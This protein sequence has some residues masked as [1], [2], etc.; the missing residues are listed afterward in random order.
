MKKQLYNV[1]V[2][3]EVIVYAV[4]E[5]SAEDIAHSAVVNGECGDADT[6]M[7]GPLQWPP[8]KELLNSIPFGDQG[9]SPDEPAYGPTGE[10][11]TVEQLIKAGAAPEYRGKKP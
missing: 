9:E 2:E 7:A 6:V 10:E 5:D 8:S 11:L 4:D 3:F 1:R